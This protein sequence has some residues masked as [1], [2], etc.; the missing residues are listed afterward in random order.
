[1][2]IV[3]FHLNRF[4]FPVRARAKRNFRLFVVV[5]NHYFI[6][7]MLAVSIHRAGI[8]TNEDQR[9]KIAIKTFHRG[10]HFFGFWKLMYDQINR[11]FVLISEEFV[12][13][14]FFLAH[15][16]RVCP[17]VSKYVIISSSTYPRTNVVSSHWH[18]SRAYQ[19]HSSRIYFR[20]CTHFLF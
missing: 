7:A 20:P 11:V 8:Y 15:V 17:F 2:H 19:H 12:Y 1:M 18:L 6:H 10:F 3:T 16:A 13:L 4:R 9:K 5:K 14:I